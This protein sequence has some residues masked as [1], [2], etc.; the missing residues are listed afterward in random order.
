MGACNCIDNREGENQI[1]TSKGMMK[2]EEHNDEFA[3][4]KE[5]FVAR[6]AR[7]NFVP[8]EKEYDLEEAKPEEMTPKGEEDQNGRVETVVEK[9][10]STGTGKAYNIYF[11]DLFFNLLK[12]MV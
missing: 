5:N 1:I 6:N 11:N 9:K 4:T 7:S 8:Q 3:E 12:V 2:F 10:V